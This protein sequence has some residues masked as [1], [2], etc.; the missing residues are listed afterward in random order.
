MSDVLNYVSPQELR[1]KSSSSARLSA[2]APARP[3]KEKPV[4]LDVK[5]SPTLEA[6]PAI[7]IQDGGLPAA[8]LKR[9]LAFIDAHLDENI[10]LADLAR[11]SN[12]SLYYFATLFRRSMGVSPHRYILNL[13]VSRA[14]ELLRNTGLSV[15]DVSLD[16]GFQHQNNFARAFRRITGMT[17]T[18]FR[19]NKRLQ[20]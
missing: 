16:L 10:T 5:K 9:V 13:R 15:L 20:K 14:R 18:G 19:R 8:R 17:P 1:N 4:R 2:Q 12:L 3:S 11:S 7:A 6:Q